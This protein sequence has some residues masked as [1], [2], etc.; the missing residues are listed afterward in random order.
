MAGDFDFENYR[1]EYDLQRKLSRK[2]SQ[3]SDDEISFLDNGIAQRLKERLAKDAVYEWITGFNLQGHSLETLEDEARYVCSLDKAF[4]SPAPSDLLSHATGVRKSY[5]EHYYSKRAV[6]TKV[7][8]TAPTPARL[9]EL[10]LYGFFKYQGHWIYL[11]RSTEDERRPLQWMV[12]PEKASPVERLG[13]SVKIRTTFLHECVPPHAVFSTLSSRNRVA[14]AEEFGSVG[15]HEEWLQSIIQNATES[16]PIRGGLSLL[17][18]GE[19]PVESYPLAEL[20]ANGG[21]IPGKKVE[22]INGNLFDLRPENYV[23]S[24]AE[25]AK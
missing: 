15:T 7:E 6:R 11:D 13:L 23:Q 18:A 14:F 12:L 25:V 9:L 4:I 20:I 3:L 22:A 8:F 24:Q 2:A 17:L 16:S 10:M 5:V 19:Y 1:R 21:H